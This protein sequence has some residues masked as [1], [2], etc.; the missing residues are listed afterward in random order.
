MPPKPRSKSTTKSSS[1]LSAIEFVGAILKPVGAAYETHISIKNQWA[2]GFNGVLSAGHKVD[3]Q[4]EAYPQNQLFL[5]ALSKCS[6]SLS[7]TLLETNRLS[8]KSGNFKALVPC[9]DADLM[10]VIEPDIPCA[11]VDDRFK[12]ALETV[13]VLASENA[14]SVVTASILM[15]G[16]SLIA[17]DRKFIM[18]AWHGVDLPPNITLPKAFVGPLTKTKKP[19]AKFGFSESSV[20]F[21]FD[22]ESWLKTQTFNDVYPD[23]NGLL[24]K[25]SNLWNVPDKFFEAIKAVEPFSEDGNIYFDAG[26]LRSHPSDTVGASFEITGTPKGVVY[27]A[28]YL[29]MLNGL[30]TKI[31]FITPHNNGYCLMFMGDNARGLIAGR[32]R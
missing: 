7:I 28:K 12:K 8:I 17:T 16:Q 20:T 15:N 26:F 22:D 29:N 27:P 31:D 24:N 11:V 4:L 30:A 10:H 18:E 23:L 1:L 21:Y 14:Q 13:G 3:E 25:Q 2:V 32:D 5:N 19:L 6:D 9:V